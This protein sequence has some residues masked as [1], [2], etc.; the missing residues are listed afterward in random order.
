VGYS[1][2]YGVELGFT[3][4]KGTD[5]LCKIKVQ[6]VQGS[7]FRVQGSGFRVQGSGFRVQGS[8]LGMG[9]KIG[10][11]FRVRA[12]GLELNWG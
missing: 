9:R 11:G 2:V 5:C 4:G 12:G 1:R 3:Y 10:L 7:G 6:G 8:G